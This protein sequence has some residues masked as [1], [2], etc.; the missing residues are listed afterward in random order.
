MFV[1][2]PL[3]QCCGFVTDEIPTSSTMETTA[4][5][6]DHRRTHCQ[7]GLAQRVANSSVS[8]Q[9]DQGCHEAEGTSAGMES[10]PPFE[11]AARFCRGGLRR[12]VRETPVDR[13]DHKQRVRP[14]CEQGDGTEQPMP[15]EG[16]E[17]S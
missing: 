16:A 11:H 9:K 14:F 2:P 15:V 13:G 8:P 1:P 12:R 7:P 3:S 4:R 17:M 10:A 5:P 6:S